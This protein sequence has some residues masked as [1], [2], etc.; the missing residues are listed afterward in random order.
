M[1]RRCVT[2]IALFA[3]LLG[4]LCRYAHSRLKAFRNL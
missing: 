1:F 3:G 2:G 4:A